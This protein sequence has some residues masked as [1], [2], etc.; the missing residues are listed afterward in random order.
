MRS[1]LTTVDEKEQVNC[2]VMCL[3]F[4]SIIN[5][6]FGTSY[7]CY[8]RCEKWKKETIFF[9]GPT[10]EEK[11]FNSKLEILKYYEF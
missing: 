3:L 10:L 7:V 4:I 9:K 6:L 1:L 5:I 2:I 8:Y 11:A